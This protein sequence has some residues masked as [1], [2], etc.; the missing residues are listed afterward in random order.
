MIHL[1]SSITLL[2]L[3]TLAF[4]SDNRSA[5]N[6]FSSGST[7]SSSQMNENFNFLASEI[8]EKDVYCNNGET[9]TDAIN[10]GYNSL[11]IYGSCNSAIGVYRLD[12]SPF[13]W[14]YSDMPNKPLS[15]LIIKG[16]N[17]DGSDSITTPTTGNFKFFVKDNSF[18]QLIKIT[19]TSEISIYEGS[20]LRMDD[21]TLNG[22]VSINNNATFLS[23]DSNITSMNDEPAIK[24]KA[25][26]HA[27]VENT[28]ITGS[29]T[30]YEAI[31]LWNNG[32]I[33]LQGTS[34]VTAPSGTSAI[35]LTT[36]SSA[37]LQD[38]VQINS[39]DQTAIYIDKNSVVELNDNVA[40][41]RSD[42]N[43]EIFVDPTSVL[44]INGSD[45][46]LANVGCEGIT[47]YV[48]VGNNNSVNISN[49]CNGYQNLVPNFIEITT[50]NCISNGY[51][52]L[53]S[54]ECSQATNLHVDIVRAETDVTGCKLLES[55]NI[56]YN[57]KITSSTPAEKN[58]VYKIYCK[59]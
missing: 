47:S 35:S 52:N 51:Q 10:E 22:Y 24:I 14:N 25:N 29:T 1:L 3:S 54:H 53:S 2:L 32:S 39:V 38:D 27:H 20:M 41:T 9:I 50:G 8:R 18:V 12:P 56:E 37:V 19:L 58:W 15:S 30:G 7:I 5:P 59:E 11:T 42:G 46:T 34:V 6:V 31:W 44:R 36:A 23:H 45:I 21:V 57:S 26:S 28:N 55:G 40:V 17:N 4:G 33:M 48:Q 16:G 43:D 49:T 13:G